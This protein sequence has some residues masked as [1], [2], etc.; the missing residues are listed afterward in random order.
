MPSNGTQLI[1]PPE[2]ARYEFPIRDDSFSLFRENIIL[3]TAWQSV[4]N[5][6]SSD[7]FRIALFGH[8]VHQSA[9][10]KKELNRIELFT[11]P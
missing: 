8:L 11:Y 3:R 2:R 10:G 7:A 6:M 5:K 9:W 4:N 1:I